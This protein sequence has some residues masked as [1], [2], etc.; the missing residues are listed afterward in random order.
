MF[1][2]YHVCNSGELRSMRLQTP[3]LGTIHGLSVILAIAASFG[4]AR[5]HSH[6]A[7]EPAEPSPSEPIKP[8]A[9]GVSQADQDAALR[10]FEEGNSSFATRS[11]AAALQAYGQAIEFWDHPA[12]RFNISECHIHL[13]QPVEAHE[14]LS[15]HS[16][17]VTRR[18][19][20][21][22]Y[23]RALTNQK[24]LNGQIARIEVINDEVGA[25]VHAQRRTADVGARHG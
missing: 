4:L 15:E 13:D 22:F 16:S 9:V 14:I 1:S 19:R 8:W 24:L 23:N 17:M 20:K 2:E 5:S 18:S 6:F 10:L 11:Y 7:D 21:R 25:I 3:T 12:I